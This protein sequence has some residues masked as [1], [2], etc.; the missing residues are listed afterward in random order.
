MNPL[1]N[2]LRT[3]PILMGRE[4]SME[5]YPDLQFGFI[6]NPDR[7]SGC[8]SVRNCPRTRSDGPDPLLTLL[9][10]PNGTPN[11]HKL[12]WR[13]NGTG[14]PSPNRRR[15]CTPKLTPHPQGLPPASTRNT[16]GAQHFQIVTLLP[17]YAYAHYSLPMGEFFTL[18]ASA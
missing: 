9:L 3:R 14:T 15:S 16:D 17:G 2:P 1:Y 7:Q 12:H 5:P 18:D 11:Y 13:W 8:G 4:M 6:D 10:R